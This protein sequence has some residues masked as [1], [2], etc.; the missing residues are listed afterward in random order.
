MKKLCFVI[1]S[2]V[3]EKS[4]QKQQKGSGSLAVEFRWMT[5]TTFR[6]SGVSTPGK[7]SEN[8]K[9]YRYCQS[10]YNHRPSGKQQ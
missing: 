7:G 10:F 3:V 4:D 2:V 6:P 5:R 8:F 9:C 1:D